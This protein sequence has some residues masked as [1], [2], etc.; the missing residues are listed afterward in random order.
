MNSAACSAADPASQTSV[1]SKKR[2]RSSKLMDHSTSGNGPR[3]W[4]SARKSQVAVLLF[5]TIAAF[6]W[7]LTLTRQFTWTRGPDLSE[8]VLPWFQLQAREWHAGRIPL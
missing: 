1:M 3:R 8:Q 2:R 6:Y 4:V 5:L 7:K